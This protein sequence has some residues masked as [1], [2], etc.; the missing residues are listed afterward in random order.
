[1]VN[2]AG[3]EN[4]LGTSESTQMALERVLQQ[5][6]SQGKFNM[7]IS[8]G[9]NPYGFDKQIIPTP[10]TT[11]TNRRNTNMIEETSYVLLVSQDQN[12][13][14]RTRIDNT[15]II[16]E[17]Q[18]TVVFGFEVGEK[19]K[20]LH[21]IH[22][23]E[24]AVATISSTTNSSVLHNRLQPH[25]YYKLSIKD[26]IVG[27]APLM[28]PNTDDDSPQLLVQDAIRTMIAWRCDRLWK[29]S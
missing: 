10:I 6:N 8:E 7:S 5:L 22:D 2:T 16:L 19:V 20:L 23:I 17:T 12:T 27:D 4:N 3:G 9:D 28:L 21:A 11:I 13:S 15:S 25:G 26:S 1:M 18:K 29:I 24:V 14:D